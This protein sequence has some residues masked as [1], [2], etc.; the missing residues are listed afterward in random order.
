MTIRIL[1]SGLLVLATLYAYIDPYDPKLVGGDR[2]LVFEG[3]LTDAVG[4]Y[5]FT[6][7]QSAGYNSL[8]SVFDQRVTGAGVS[9]TDGDGAVVRFL[10]VGRGTY[11][12]P[13]G[14]R[15]KTGKRYVLTVTYREQTYQSAPEVMQ[16]VPPIDSVYWQYQAKP[17]TVQ[18]GY[19][20]TY[21]NLTDPAA[22]ENQYQWDWIHYDQ[23]GY[24]VLFRP[25]GP[26]TFAKPCCTNYWNITR[27]SGTS[28]LASD[29]LINGK[30]LLGQAITEVPFDDITPYYLAIGQQSLSRE[31]FQYWQTV[32][33]LTSNVGGVFDATPATLRGNICNVNADGPPM[34]G[35]L[36]VSARR[37]TVVYVSR[38]GAPGQPFAQNVYPVWPT[39]E[40]CVESLFR[41]AIRPEGWQ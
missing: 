11:E 14:F 41:T 32:Q 13:P 24:C 2:Y 23:P 7:S 28:L 3:T 40:P 18:P 29:R 8:E 16:P 19:F 22:T 38:L 9:V 39:C 1:L 30:R 6:L 17:T 35:F 37:Q 33:A 4:P 20:T 31:A 10:D 12:S 36:Q 25:D 5:R 27:S 26:A 15:G 21:L 34:L